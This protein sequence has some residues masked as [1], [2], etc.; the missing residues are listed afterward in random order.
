MIRKVF[1]TVTTIILITAV[2]AGMVSALDFSQ[3]AVVKANLENVRAY[4]A[5]THPSGVNY[6]V[7]GGEL[8]AGRTGEWRHVTTPDNVIVGAV[9]ID[10][11]SPKTIYIGAAN[12]MAIYRSQDRGNGWSRIPL[13]KEF[14]GGVTSL[15]VDSVNHLVY[16][17]TDTAGVFRL[18]DVGS[19]LI[20]GGHMKLDE[21]VLQVASDN[22]GAGLA[23]VRTAMNIYRAENGGLNWAKVENLGSTP[24]ALAIANRYPA[25]VYVGTA[26]RGLLTSRDGL[27]WEMANDGLGLVP[28]SR[29]H[30]DAL[31]VDP[32]QLDVLYVATSYLYGSTQV[33]Q[34]PVG[35]AMSTNGGAS[36]DTLASNDKIAMV[37]LLPLAGQTGAL[38]ALTAN[39]RTPLALGSAPVIAEST[40]MA[41]ASRQHPGAG[42]Y[43][44][45]GLVRRSVGRRGPGLCPGH[46]RR[47]P[48]RQAHPAGGGATADGQPHTVEWSSFPTASGKSPSRIIGEDSSFYDGKG[49]ARG[50]KGDG[51]LSIVNCQLSMGRAATLPV[52]RMPNP[53]QSIL[54]APISLR[55]IAVA[56][57][58]NNLLTD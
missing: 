57:S 45:G 56:M 49:G 52:L 26:D 42:Q 41:Q 32:A 55:A 8:F 34:T 43:Q 38:F 27:T 19:S 6:A 15:A 31:T 9:A 50:G 37:E 13:T 3:A 5:A 53:H 23:F 2:F 4:A 28:G 40:A 29:L 17:G 30:V 35:V 20:S 18:R 10:M 25:T 54:N 36:W 47:A 11:A 21:P 22:T 33:H 44:R 14:V 24:T 46:R 39:S 58:L 48:R 7:D 1:F 16:A 12:E 51:Q